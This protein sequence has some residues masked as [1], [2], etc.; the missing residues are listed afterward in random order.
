MVGLLFQHKVTSV[1]INCVC[2]SRHS[3]HSYCDKH[4]E[5][6]QIFT[7]IALQL[8]KR[9]FILISSP[10]GSS[11]PKLIGEYWLVLYESIPGIAVEVLVIE[12]NA[13]KIEW[14]QN[15]L[16]FFVSV[17]LTVGSVNCWFV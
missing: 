13:S 15:S 16:T 2:A 9:E 6:I 1:D 3:Q 12:T 17:S 14:R 10:F 4:C 11:P 7:V 5:G 8:N